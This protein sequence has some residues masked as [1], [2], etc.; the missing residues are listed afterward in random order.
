MGNENK[1]TSMLQQIV[2]SRWCHHAPTLGAIDSKSSIGGAIC[3][4]TRFGIIALIFGL[5]II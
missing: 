1:F 2:G 4:P 5:R 3:V